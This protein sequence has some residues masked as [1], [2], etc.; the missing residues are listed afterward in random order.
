MIDI[1]LVEPQINENIGFVVRSMNVFGCN[2]LVIINPPGDYQ[3][4]ARITA[5]RSASIL[6]SSKVFSSFD[7]VVSSYDVLVATSRRPGG[8]REPIYTP[9]QTAEFIRSLPIKYS[10]G[11]VF[12]REDT[13]LYAEEI[14]QCRIVSSIPS[15]NDTVSLNISH[16]VSIYL[17]E[18]HQ[19]FHTERDKKTN[20]S[21]PATD[22]ELISLAHH[23]FTLLETTHFIKYGDKFLKQTLLH[24]LKKP[25]LEKKDVKLLEAICYHVDKLIEPLK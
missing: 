5:S 25:V 7:E 12:G 16:A 11:L 19:F 6:D 2:K 4:K 3:E 10:V 21:D 1:V 14:E 22:K 15:Y 9:E 18:L 17:Y 23:I 20:P 13:G 8:L 24:L